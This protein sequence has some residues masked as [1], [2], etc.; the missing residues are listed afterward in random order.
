MRRRNSVTSVS[1][2][3]TRNERI[4]GLSAMAGSCG[5]GVEGDGVGVAAGEY[6]GNSDATVVAA[7]SL[8]PS[9]RVIRPR[10]VASGR[11][12]VMVARRVGVPAQCNDLNAVL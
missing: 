8:R 1:G 7:V 6:A 3:L 4:A 12:K 9:R 10:A 11:L 2:K 5:V